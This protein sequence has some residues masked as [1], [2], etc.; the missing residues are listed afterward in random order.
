MRPC[1]S[2][3]APPGEAIRFLSDPQRLS[4]SIAGSLQTDMIQA[5][6]N[7]HRR[8]PPTVQAPPLRFCSSILRIK[9]GRLANRSSKPGV[10]ASLSHTSSLRPA[11][12]MTTSVPILVRSRCILGIEMRPAVSISSRSVIPKK[13]ASSPAS[14]SPGVRV[15]SPFSANSWKPRLRVQH[16]PLLA[17]GNAVPGVPISLGSQQ[18]TV[19]GGYRQTLLC[20]DGQLGMAGEDH[21]CF[22][23]LPSQRLHAQ[24]HDGHILARCGNLPHIAPLCN[25]SIHVV[26]DL[27]TSCPGIRPIT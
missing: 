14:S 9:P 15:A 8:V 19:L 26:G 2:H 4:F 3:T 12:I 24:S 16:Q 1:T 27:W 23:W 17:P 5:L 6:T 10:H 7:L 22:P 21:A 11:P 13:L 18:G 20:V 25:T